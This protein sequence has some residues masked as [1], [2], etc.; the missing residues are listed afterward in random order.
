MPLIRGSSVGNVLTA[1][2]SAAT[3]YQCFRGG[4]NDLRTE[5]FP[6]G[7]CGGLVMVVQL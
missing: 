6:G 2:K 5:G 7:Q 3:W 4:G 1:R